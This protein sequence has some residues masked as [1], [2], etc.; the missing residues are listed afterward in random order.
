MLPKRWAFRKSGARRLL[1]LSTR[2]RRTIAKEVNR[3]KMTE[4]DFLPLK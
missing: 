2:E 1:Y 4:L 3:S